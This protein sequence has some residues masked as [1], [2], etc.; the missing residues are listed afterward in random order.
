MLANTLTVQDEEEV[1]EE[2]KALQREA[3]RGLPSCLVDI[4]LTRNGRCCVAWGARAGSAHPAPIS[5]QDE[6]SGGGTPRRYA[7]SRWAS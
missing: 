2:L 7:L 5:T 1:L 4:E 6:T 3:V